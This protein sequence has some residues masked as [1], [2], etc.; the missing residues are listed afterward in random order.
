MGTVRGL[1]SSEEFKNPFASLVKSGE[2]A[3][4]AFDAILAD[5]MSEPAH[6][7]RVFAVLG[8]VKANRDRFVE[9]TVSRLADTD[10]R[11]RR[12]AVILL[13]QIGGPRDTPPVVALLSDKDRTVSYAAAK[14]L[15]A[16]GGSRDLTAIEV[17]L[18]A[19]NHRDDGELLGHVAKCRDE[20]KQR[21][22]KEKK[23]R[24]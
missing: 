5:P 6:V 11:V 8:H 7:A 1:L 16:I 12:C 9:P 14:S 2:R 3:F 20:L 13:G 10:P 21:L 23:A 17:W 19:G 15:A 24:N 22:E 18:R 4:P